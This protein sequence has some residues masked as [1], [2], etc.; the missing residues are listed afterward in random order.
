VIG[1]AQQWQNEDGQFQIT[2]EQMRALLDQARGIMATAASSASQGESPEATA[3]VSIAKD[4]QG[5]KGDPRQQGGR[6]PWDQSRR[7]DGWWNDF[8]SWKNYAGGWTDRSHGWKYIGWENWNWHENTWSEPSNAQK[9]KSDEKPR[10]KDFTDLDAWSRW[11]E[12][13]LWRRKIMRWRQTTDVVRHKHADRIMKLLPLDLQRKLEDI[14]DEDLISDGGADKVIARLD[15]LWE[16]ESEMKT[17]GANISATNGPR[18]TTLSNQR[19]PGKVSLYMGPTNSAD[20]RGADSLLDWDDASS[21]DAEGEAETYVALDQMDLYDD[22]LKYVFSTMQED[23]R[24]TWEQNR[25]L[26]RKLKVDR[27]FLDRSREIE[28]KV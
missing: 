16:K 20:D 26:K 22:E 23:R 8:S 18:L 19:L 2:M 25:A 28:I 27:K 3:D 17:Q 5:E 9:W 14:T 4:G 1:I 12:Y 11:P 6:D 7:S 13:K 10:G 21:L 15:L 24:K